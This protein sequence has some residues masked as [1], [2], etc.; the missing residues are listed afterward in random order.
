MYFALIPDEKTKADLAAMVQ[1]PPEEFHLTLLF[2]PDRETR[3]PPEEVEE[4]RREDPLIHADV[5]GLSNFG[6]PAKR[7]W[8]LQ[9]DPG[10]LTFMR[11][12]LQDLLAKHN[13]PWDKT[14][15]F[16][17]HVTIGKKAGITLLGALPEALTFDRIELRY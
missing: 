5:V 14:W 1:D 13:I 6:P 8:A 12:I 3:I 9:L 4:A 17:P 7:V 10:S 2:S 16:N 15:L 11:S